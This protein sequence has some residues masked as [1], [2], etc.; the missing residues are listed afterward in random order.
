MPYVA[1]DVQQN[2]KLEFERLN[3]LAIGTA[4]LISGLTSSLRG[5]ATQ[6][7][8]VGKHQAPGLDHP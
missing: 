1:L 6:E 5:R 4:A 8:A 2:H 7:R 3:R